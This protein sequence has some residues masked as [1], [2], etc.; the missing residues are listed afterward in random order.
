MF[1]LFGKRSTSGSPHLVEQVARSMCRRGNVGVSI[2]S[3]AHFIENFPDDRSGN[4]GKK[5]N[6]DFFGR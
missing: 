3:V 4:P 5:S 6:F 1:K 2:L